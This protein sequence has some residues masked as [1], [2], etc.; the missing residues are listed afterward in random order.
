MKYQVQSIPRS[1]RLVSCFTMSNSMTTPHPK[2][3]VYIYICL[4][5][6]CPIQWP[7]Q[8]PLKIYVEMFTAMTSTQVVS[9]AC[10]LVELKNDM[11]KEL[12]FITIHK[13]ASFD[14]GS[15]MILLQAQF[16]NIE[17]QSQLPKILKV[18]HWKNYCISFWWSPISI[19]IYLYGWQCLT[20]Q[21]MCS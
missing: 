8:P 6:K 13:V 9:I 3:D 15:C 4:A 18:T 17:K 19:M 7:P 14:G 16:C 11:L 20:P 21:S 12:Y 1:E 5:S 10:D 2:I